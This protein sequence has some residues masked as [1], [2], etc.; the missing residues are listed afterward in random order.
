MKKAKI[1]K[2]TNNNSYN[3]IMWPKRAAERQKQ[4]FLIGANSWSLWDFS[5]HDQFID[6]DTYYLQ[7]E[8]DKKRIKI[9]EASQYGITVEW[10]PV[11]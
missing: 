1:V 11:S 2:I 8:G 9:D 4:A 3:Q 7:F 6:L 5:T 10:F